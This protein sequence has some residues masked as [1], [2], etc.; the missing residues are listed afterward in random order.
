M[1]CISTTQRHK[2]QFPIFEILIFRFK[3]NAG[4]TFRR[5][6][7]TAPTLRQQQEPV[8]VVRNRVGGPVVNE[9]EHKTINWNSDD[10]VHVLVLY[11]GLVHVP[12]MVHLASIVCHQSLVVCL[13]SQGSGC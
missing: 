6:N 8:F 9:T 13:L 12:Y 7:K 5:A 10:Q 11:K 2:M 3:K 4:E 1:L